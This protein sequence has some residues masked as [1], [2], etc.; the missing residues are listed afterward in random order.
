MILSQQSYAE[1]LG[2]SDLLLEGHINVELQLQLEFFYFSNRGEIY[3]I[4]KTCSAIE[5]KKMWIE[6]K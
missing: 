1:W 3:L 6:K 5:K 4:T 2:Y